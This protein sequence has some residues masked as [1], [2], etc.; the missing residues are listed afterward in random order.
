MKGTISRYGVDDRDR[1]LG[2]IDVRG[3]RDVRNGRDSTLSTSRRQLDDLVAGGDRA[4]DDHRGA[5]A[6]QAV[7]PADP[8]VDETMCLEPEALRELRAA[9]VRLR[10]HLDH[11]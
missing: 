9:G 8:A 5:D 2:E 4:S 6:A 10:R 1:H 7:L 11:R 3:G